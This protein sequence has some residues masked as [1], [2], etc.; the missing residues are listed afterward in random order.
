MNHF[1]YFMREPW[2]W[3]GVECGFGQASEE[4]VRF[5]GR[6]GQ[7][8]DSACRIIC[9]AAGRLSGSECVSIVKKSCLPK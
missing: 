9:S 5:C 6:F 3:G 1:V 2:G 7:A 4:S 8:A